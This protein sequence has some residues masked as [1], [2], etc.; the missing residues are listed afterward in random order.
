MTSCKVL[1]I[2]LYRAEFQL[3][4]YPCLRLH[5][6]AFVMHDL[7]FDLKCILINYTKFILNKYS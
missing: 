4:F 7:G 5:L 3:H 2:E 6:N 1:D